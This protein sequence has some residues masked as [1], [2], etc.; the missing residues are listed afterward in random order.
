MA[1]IT[2]EEAL[3]RILAYVSVMPAE[4]K[5]PLEALGQ[6]LD[7]DIA[8]TFEIPPLDNTSMDGY[9]VR[10]AATAAASE[11]SARELRVIGE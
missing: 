3:E 4:E 5:H 7:E 1:M 11:S 10:A 9:A 8:A 6:V 2:I